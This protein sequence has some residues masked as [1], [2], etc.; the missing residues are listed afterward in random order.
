M[1]NLSEEVFKSPELL[2]REFE[3]DKKKRKKRPQSFEEL[4]AQQDLAD[5]KKNEQ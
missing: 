5:T 4:K 1:R 2:K 3:R